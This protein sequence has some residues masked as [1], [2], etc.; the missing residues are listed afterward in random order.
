VYI[1][2]FVV[3]VGPKRTYLFLKRLISQKGMVGKIRRIK[4]V[5][6]A[7]CLEMG[8]RL[9]IYTYEVILTWFRPVLKPR[10][11]KVGL[12]ECQRFIRT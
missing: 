5:F 9:F 3:G 6:F 8:A 1:T 2:I 10:P 4:S 7:K 12:K 11:E